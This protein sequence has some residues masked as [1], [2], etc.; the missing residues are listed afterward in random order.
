[1]TDN[2]YQVKMLTP[3][4]AFSIHIIHGKRP[5]ILPDLPTDYPSMPRAM[6][7]E[8]QTCEPFLVFTA[9]SGPHLQ[10]MYV[11]YLVF[12]Q[13]L[14]Y[15]ISN[16]DMKSR[17]PASSEHRSC[18]VIELEGKSR[19]RPWT[20]QAGF[21][22]S[23][24]HVS[25]GFCFLWCLVAPVF[26]IFLYYCVL[27]MLYYQWTTFFSLLYL[28]LKTIINQKNVHEFLFRSLLICL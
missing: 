5:R 3:S 15:H 27:M 19:Q 16:G 6:C 1:M 20:V 12:C 18:G 11:V 17:S 26:A 13:Q 28:W 9:G 23:W 22:T 10:H 8:K 2:Q 14:T 4:A 21:A 25:K 24:I 7:F